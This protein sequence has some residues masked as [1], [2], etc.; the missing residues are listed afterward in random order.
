METLLPYFLKVS[1]LISV[2]YLVYYFVLKRDT[3]FNGNRAYLLLGILTSVVLPLVFFTKKI[4]IKTSSLA[5]GNILEPSLFVSNPQVV[6]EETI[7]WLNIGISAYVVVL[8]GLLLKLGWEYFSLKRLLNK[9]ISVKYD[10]F[11][12]YDVKDEIKPFSYFKNIVFNSQMF[13]NQELQS[14]LQHEKVHSSQWHSVDV[15]LS[16][17]FCVVFWWN[18]ISWLYHKAI[19]QNLEFIADNQAVRELDDARSYQYTLL[20]I[21]SA[22]HGVSIINNFNQSLIKKR[23]VM[24]NKSKSNRWNAAKYLLLLPV[25]GLFLW[26]FQVKEVYTF[27]PDFQS[28]ESNTISWGVKIDKNTTDAR[29]K[30]FVTKAK[31]KGLNLKFSK[32][33]RNND[34]EITSIKVVYKG[35]NDKG[36]TAHYSSTEPIESFTI[37]IDNNGLTQVKQKSSNTIDLS[38][39]AFA[40]VGNLNEENADSVMVNGK[41]YVVAIGD[42]EPP[43]PPSFDAAEPVEPMAIT[44]DAMVVVNGISLSDHLKDE[45]LKINANKVIIKTKSGQESFVINNNVDFDKI[46]TYISNLKGDELGNFEIL[47]DFDDM[48]L[49]VQS[50]KELNAKELKKLKEKALENRSKSI[51]IK[52]GS[53]N[54]AKLYKKEMEQSRK[55]I[56]ISMKEIENS[57]KELEIAKKEIELARKEIAKAKEELRQLELK[58]SKNQK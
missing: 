56:E 33:K 28:V 3:F 11:K 44:E 26:S 31:A 8:I 53:Y 32:I 29:L 58:K 57:K 47:A 52:K 55:E 25:L 10:G 9:R 40:V 18:P 22:N 19:L 17:L 46:E 48:N 14:I 2:F 1:G 49:I 39:Q 24:L 35:K 27:L 41:G 37:E 43:T 45:A 4:E 36:G 23:I 16:R 15:L 42:Y 50:V 51:Q 20:K 30:E 12:L 7:D 21:T 6:V 34:G 13:S 5:T 54:D 38:A